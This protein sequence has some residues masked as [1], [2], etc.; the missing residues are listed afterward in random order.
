[1]SVDVFYTLDFRISKKNAD[2]DEISLR[3]GLKPSHA[4][5]AG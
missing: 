3:L 5:R 2:P 1:M 4:R